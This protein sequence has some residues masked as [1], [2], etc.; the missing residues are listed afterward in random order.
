MDPVP[1]VAGAAARVALWALTAL[2]GGAL[3]AAAMLALTGELTAWG[4]ALYAAVTGVLGA[5]AGS[6][7]V[8]DRF[9]RALADLLVARRL[10]INQKGGTR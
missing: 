1:S 4:R 2:A 7:L 10:K 6:V 8:A 9:G 3:A 5:V